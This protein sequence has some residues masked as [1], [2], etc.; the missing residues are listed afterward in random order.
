MMICPFCEAVIGDQD[1]I[2]GDC[3]YNPQ[4]DTMT[5]SFVRKKKAVVVEQ[6]QRM[7]SPKIKSFVFWGIMII[8]LSLGIKYQVKIGDLVWKAKNI[9]LGNKVNSSAQASGKAQPNKVLGLRDVRTYQA[10]ADKSLGKNKKIE[11]I[12]YDPQGKSFVMINDQLISEQMN[13][14]DMLIMKINHD[15]VEVVQDGKKKVLRVNKQ[16]TK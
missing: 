1:K 8:V 11:G 14:G 4:T 10:P 7:L 12:F 16:A 3:G 13:F 9:L 6:K 2:C 5:K 15:S